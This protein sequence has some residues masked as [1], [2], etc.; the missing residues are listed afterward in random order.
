MVGEAALIV[1]VKLFEVPAVVDT[2]TV[3]APAF[4]TRLAGTVAVKEVALT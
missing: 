4:A 3:A 1:K 2:V